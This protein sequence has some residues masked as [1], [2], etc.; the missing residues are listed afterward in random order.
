VKRR[1]R[2]TMTAD[3]DTTTEPFP[4]QKELALFCRERR[5]CVVGRFPRNIRRNIRRYRRYA[6]LTES[7]QTCY[8]RPASRASAR[9]S[10]AG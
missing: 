4:T 8:N 1:V 5:R 10:V 7:D 3:R 9:R 6:R 2:R